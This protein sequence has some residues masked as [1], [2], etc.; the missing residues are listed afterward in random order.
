[1]CR[2]VRREYSVDEYHEGAIYGDS[3][4]CIVG[5]GLFG[6]IIIII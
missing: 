5:S 3:H 2:C 4:M 1:M 6:L